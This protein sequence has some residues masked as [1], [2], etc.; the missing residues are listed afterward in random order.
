MNKSFY[1]E[2]LFIRV[3]H[4]RMSNIFRYSTFSIKKSSI[5]L[6]LHLILSLS[7]I[8]TTMRKKKKTPTTTT[9]H[10]P[11][12]QLNHHILLKKKITVYNII[13]NPI[14]KQK[15]RNEV[16]QIISPNPWAGK[17]WSSLNM[18]Q[19]NTNHKPQILGTWKPN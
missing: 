12:P 6:P 18:A 15:R 19:L 8:S 10:Q 14:E 5:S 16:P 4:S 17:S 2:L 9:T 13:R 11:P 1:N 7:E 3:Y